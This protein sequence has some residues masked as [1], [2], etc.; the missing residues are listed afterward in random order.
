MDAEAIR[1]NL[2][3]KVDLSQFPKPSPRGRCVHL[4]KCRNHL[5]SKFYAGVKTEGPKNSLFSGSKRRIG[6]GKD[7][8]GVAQLVLGQSQCVKPILLANQFLDQLGQGVISSVGDAVGDY[9]K[10]ER[11]MAAEL[12][13][14][15]SGWQVGIHP[16]ASNKLTEKIQRFLRRQYLQGQPHGALPHGKPR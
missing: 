11:K 1:R 7:N 8:A 4:G 2:L 5:S 13:N 14:A 3:D 12:S 9:S 16:L 15:A 10:R 6:P